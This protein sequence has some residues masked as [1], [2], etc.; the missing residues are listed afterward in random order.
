MNRSYKFAFAAAIAAVSVSG[1]GDSAQQQAKAVQQ[2][3]VESY[4]V[5]CKNDAGAVTF[6][7]VVRNAGTPVR[8][9]NIPNKPALSDVMDKEKGAM[10][11]QKG[12][13]CT[14]VVK[15]AV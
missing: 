12:G 6:N 2:D 14:A 5:T 10:H 4:D 15:K 8:T 1:C 11:S 9:Y 13:T 3:V 7:A